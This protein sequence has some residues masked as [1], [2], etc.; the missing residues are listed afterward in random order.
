MREGPVRVRVRQ[1]A[2]ETVLTIAPADRALL[3]EA[4]RATLAT[5][6]RGGRPRLLPICFVVVDDA[7][8][9]PIDEKPK[10][11][12]DP[13]ALARLRDIQ[14]D[15]RVTL[16]VDRWSEDWSELAWL[17]VEGRAAVVDSDPAV[18][19]ALRGRYPQ[20]ADHDLESRPMIRITIERVLGW[21]A[22]STDRDATGR[23]VE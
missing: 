18:A 10:A 17:R 15:A 12:D 2:S 23:T 3:R 21:G 8:W 7:V 5:I 22:S 16:L 13:R 9:S 14:R 4:R 1:R 20:Y 19:G 11:V 6:D